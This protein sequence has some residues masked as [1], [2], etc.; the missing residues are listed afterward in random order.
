VNIEVEIERW[1]LDGVTTQTVDL[2]SHEEVVNDAMKAD[3]PLG[4][5][6][7]ALPCASGH[8][9]VVSL[10]CPVE[11]PCVHRSSD[12]IRDHG[13]KQ[14]EAAFRDALDCPWMTVHEAREALPPVY[15]EWIG[16]QLIERLRAVA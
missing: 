16:C 10:S 11:F 12:A 1:T 15:T 8:L 9:H 5:Y 13:G 14:T 6:L 4:A 7:L 3:T 2:E